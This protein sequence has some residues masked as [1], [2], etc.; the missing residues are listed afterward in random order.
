MNFKQ[1]IVDILR[2]H[3]IKDEPTWANER[4]CR[5][6]ESLHT[7]ISPH[8][9]VRAA[10]VDELA[11]WDFLMELLDHHYPAGTFPTREDDPGRIDQIRVS[12]G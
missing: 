5:C 12:A 9:T 4:I 10:L 7:F 8:H 3:E 6:G 1:R 11:S 2:R